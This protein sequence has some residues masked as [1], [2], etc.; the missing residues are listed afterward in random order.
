MQS[1]FGLCFSTL[2]LTCA[3]QL[4][5]S[6]TVALTNSANEEGATAVPQHFVCNTGF[7]PAVP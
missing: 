3:V 7:G 1:S 4:A 5:A 6:Q 2:L